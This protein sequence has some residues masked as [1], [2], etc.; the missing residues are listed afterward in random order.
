VKS[1]SEIVLEVISGIEFCLH[2]RAIA[3]V[4]WRDGCPGFPERFDPWPAFWAILRAKDEKAV[5]YLGC[6]RISF[7]GKGISGFF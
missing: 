2:G 5:W 6:H 4:D 1:G 3:V 7:Q